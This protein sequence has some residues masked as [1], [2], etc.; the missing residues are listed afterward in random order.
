[1]M[2]AETFITLRRAQYAGCLYGDPAENAK[3]FLYA[4]MERMPHHTGYRGAHAQ[5]YH[6]WRTGWLIICL[7]QFTPWGY[8][9][10]P[11]VKAR[12]QVGSH[13]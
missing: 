1:M 7:D 11:E 4:Y 8:K 10:E 12:Q 3:S 6:L 13:V 5:Q 9:S 2:D